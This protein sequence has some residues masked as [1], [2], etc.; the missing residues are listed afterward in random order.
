MLSQSFC[1]I[2]FFI[3]HCTNFMV[4]LIIVQ[5]TFLTSSLYSPNLFAKQTHHEQKC[6]QINRQCKTGIKELPIP[7]Q[8][9][10]IIFAISSIQ[11]AND[12]S[13]R[14]DGIATSRRHPPKTR[15]VFSFDQEDSRCLLERQT[16]KR[17][18]RAL[19]RASRASDS[20]STSRATSASGRRFPSTAHRKNNND[21]AIVGRKNDQRRRNWRNGN[22]NG[23]LRDQRYH[24]SAHF[25]RV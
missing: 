23:R 24:F 12:N 14:P 3:R 20:F 21:C 8:L 18:G 13:N 22:E 9:A 10:P 15:I 7:S 2:C 1:S 11:P 6:M 16:R 25:I 17:G 19:L 5:L 4:F